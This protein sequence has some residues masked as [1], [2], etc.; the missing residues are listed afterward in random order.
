MHWATLRRHSCLSRVATFASSQVS[1]IFRKSFLTVPIQ[2]P[3]GRLGPLLKPGTSQYSA[4]CG[5][6]ATNTTNWDTHVNTSPC[7]LH[8]AIYWNLTVSVL[9]VEHHGCNGVETRDSINQGPGV[10]WGPRIGRH[11]KGTITLGGLGFVPDPM[12]KLTAL[13]LVQRTRGVL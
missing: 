11:E 3:L 9:I 12:G 4:C 13:T 2:L 5:I 8:C 10:F 1:V 6:I 7:S